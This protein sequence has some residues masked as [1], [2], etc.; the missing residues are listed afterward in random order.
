MIMVPSPKRPRRGPQTERVV[1][2]N[3]TKWKKGDVRRIEPYY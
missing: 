2:S 1:S 3:H